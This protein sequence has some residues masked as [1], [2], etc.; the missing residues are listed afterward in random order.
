MM[1]N[2]AYCVAAALPPLC[3]AIY[4]QHRYHLLRRKAEEARRDPVAADLSLATTE[5]I[6]LSLRA[7]SRAG[8]LMLTYCAE[9]SPHGG[10]EGSMVCRAWNLPQGIVEQLVEVAKQS[11]KR[12]EE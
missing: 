3:A 9:Q 12:E 11:C 6:L 4:W 5:Q 2:L 7:R 8:F 10:A 1:L